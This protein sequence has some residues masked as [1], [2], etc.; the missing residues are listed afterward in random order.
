MTA[1]TLALTLVAA[2]LAVA[3]P[4]AAADNQPVDANGKKSC[5]LKASKDS[6][7]WRPHG[8]T[9]SGTTPQGT[10]FTAKCDDGSWKVERAAVGVSLTADTTVRTVA[11]GV[12]TLQARA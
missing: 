12:V 11:Y 10:Q 1:R 7:V 6:T 5:A 3:G 9:I 4:A 8:T 2:A